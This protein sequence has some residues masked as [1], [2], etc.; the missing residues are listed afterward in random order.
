MKREISGTL[1]TFDI[2]FFEWIVE[3][4]KAEKISVQEKL[5]L[6][7]TLQIFGT[8]TIIQSYAFDSAFPF[9]VFTFHPPLRFERKLNE[10][11]ETVSV[12]IRSTGLRTDQ[13]LLN[14]SKKRSDSKT[15]TTRKCNTEAKTF[16]FSLKHI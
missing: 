11:P 8:S 1:Q 3:E 5:K 2:G 14:G 4:D 6:Q 15:L 7:L 9:G 12:Q 13:R 10:R 16:P